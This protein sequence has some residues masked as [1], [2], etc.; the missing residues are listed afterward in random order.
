ML[1]KLKILVLAAI[2]LLLLVMVFFSFIYKGSRSNLQPSSSLSQEDLVARGQYL[3][4]AGDC[5][6]CHSSAGGKPFTGGIGITSP[7]G[8]IYPTN[9]T[10]DKE[11]GIGNYSLQDFDNALRYGVRR[12]GESLYP[13]MPYPDFSRITDEDVEALYAYFMHGVEPVAQANRAEGIPWPLSMRW[14]L[15]A[16]RMA[17]APHVQPFVA[18]SGQD[19]MRARGAYLV[20]GLGHCGTCHTPRNSLTL[21]EKGYTEADASFLSGSG[22]PIDGWVAINLHGD[23]KDGLGSMSEEQLYMLL[24]TGRND[25]S[26]VFGGMSDVINDSLQHM[27]D[28]DLHAMAHYLKSLPPVNQNDKPFEPNAAVATALAEGKDG[29]IRGAQVFVDNCAACH[30]TSGQGYTQTFPSLAGNP[31]VHSENPA[32]IINIVLKGHVLEGTVGAPTR[33]T[34]PPFAWRLNDQEVADVVTFVRTSWGNEGKPVDA[35]EVAKYRREL[36]ADAAKM[37]VA[38]P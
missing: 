19:E 18:A 37:P 17:F 14:P 12:N 22:S 31:V 21:S 26:A 29:D 32:S 6:A 25:H 10:P 9:I 8:K 38:T 4:F 15:A 16:W 30:R 1:K 35:A 5:M 13:A 23:Y 11:T 3:S 7:V 2:L 28:D 27:S 24:K 33:Y 20:Q 36:P 34:M